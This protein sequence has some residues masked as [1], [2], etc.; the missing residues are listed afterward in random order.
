MR[1][2]VR[3]RQSRDKVNG[4]YKTKENGLRNNKQSIAKQSI[5]IQIML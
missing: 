3:R 2:R 1:K 4:Q 5:A